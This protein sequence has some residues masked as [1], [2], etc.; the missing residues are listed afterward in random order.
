MWRRRETGRTTLT[1]RRKAYNGKAIHA[2]SG[3]SRNIRNAVNTSE[4]FRKMACQKY[5]DSSCGTARK[6]CARNLAGRLV[7]YFAVIVWL[8][9]GTP[10]VG[11]LWARV[12]FNKA[13]N[14]VGLRHNIGNAVSANEAFRKMSC[15][16]YRDSSCGRA[17]KYCARH[18]A[19]RLAGRFAVI[20]WPSRGTPRGHRRDSS[21]PQK[22][23]ECTG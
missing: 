14:M 11:E 10:F 16:I 8:S 9:R 18:F 3:C 21:E 13:I 4:T 12:M 6:H 20:A 2:E 17:C 1:T 15:R 5:R 22:Q 19:G 7:G 23:C